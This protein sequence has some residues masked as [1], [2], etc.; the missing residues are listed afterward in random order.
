MGSE[1]GHSELILS[2]LGSQLVFLSFH[3]LMSCP[4]CQLSSSS[5]SL[6]QWLPSCFGEGCWWAG[7]WSL[8]T[9]PSAGPHTALGLQS[10]LKAWMSEWGV[11][12]RVQVNITF[13]YFTCRLWAELQQS[14]MS[15]A[16]EEN[17]PTFL[18]H[19]YIS[20][21]FITFPAIPSSWDFN[22]TI[23]KA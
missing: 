15:P 19:L 3:P 21:N 14:V 18:K 2:G 8:S 1:G 7:Q 6:A 23:P 4:S 17:P 9:G 10:E 12:P 5:W 22:P 20:L 11:N 13:F 16:T